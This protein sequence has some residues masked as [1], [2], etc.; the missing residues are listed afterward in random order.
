M[1]RAFVA[2]VT[3]VRAP[4]GRTVGLTARDRLSGKARQPTRREVLWS[5]S[6]VRMRELR[7]SRRWIWR[8][9][10]QGSLPTFRWDLLPPSS[11]QKSAPAPSSGMWCRVGIVTRF[12]VT[13]CFSFL[14][15]SVLFYYILE[16]D[17]PQSGTSSQTFWRNFLPLCLG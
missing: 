6:D 11:G 8:R 4:A 9:V 15:R 13:C 1:T 3:L 7:F 16:C 12:G 2:D 17:A 14:G 10:F 5:P